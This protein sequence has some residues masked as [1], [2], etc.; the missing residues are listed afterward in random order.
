MLRDLRPNSLPPD[1]CGLSDPESLPWRCFLYLE[2]DGSGY[3]LTYCGNP[4]PAGTAWQHSPAEM[5][6]ELRGLDDDDRCPIYAVADLDAALVLT[7][8]LEDL[9]RCHDAAAMRRCLGNIQPRPN[10]FNR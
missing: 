1:Q 10:L 6:L 3:H 2:G 4:I 7:D 8:Y 5:R 9:G